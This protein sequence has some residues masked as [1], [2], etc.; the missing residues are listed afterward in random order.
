MCDVGWVWAVINGNCII[1]DEICT[2][3][4]GIDLSS[5]KWDLHVH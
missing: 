3:L 2:V 5:N 1:I 4:N